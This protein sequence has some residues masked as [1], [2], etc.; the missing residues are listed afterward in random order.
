MHVRKTLLL[1]L[2]MFGLA[3]CGQETLEFRNAEIVGGKLYREG[4]DK[5]FTGRVENIPFKLIN[6]DMLRDFFMAKDKYASYHSEIAR[7]DQ[8]H[9]V[10]TASLICSGSSEDGLSDGAYICRHPNEQHEVLEFELGGS[11][12]EDIVMYSRRKPGVKIIVGEHRDH[13]LHGKFEIYSAESGKVLYSTTY[14]GG[15]LIG[16]TSAYNAYTEVLAES[17]TMDA[18]SGIEEVIQY[19]EDGVTKRLLTRYK[20]GYQ[21]GEA[22][23]LDQD[24]TEVSTAA[25]DDSTDACVDAWVNAHRAVVGEDAVII[26]DQLVEW[27]DFCKKGE[28]PPPAETEA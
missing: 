7:P 26:H 5:P 25:S 13:R 20:N 8:Q 1:S 3:A 23:A 19:A 6:N 28:M 11:G 21:F 12:N 15:K 10:H 18:E 16:P 24:A 4:E 17:R 27:E 22:I 2:C 9:Y 14:D